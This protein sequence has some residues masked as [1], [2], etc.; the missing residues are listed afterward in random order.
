MSQGDFKTMLAS[1]TPEQRA[2]LEKQFENKTPEQIRAEG[3][4]GMEKVTGFRILDQKTLSD[5]EVMLRV[6]A[7]GE[8]HA[9]KMLMRRMGAEWKMAGPYRDKN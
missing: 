3:K 1:V 4:R 9:Q 6:F 8:N 2:S 5:S 7:D